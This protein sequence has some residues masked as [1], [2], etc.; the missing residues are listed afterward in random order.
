MSKRD[1]TGTLLFAILVGLLL[2]ALA[3]ASAD[4]IHLSDGRKLEGEI[5]KETEDSI[6]LKMQYGTLTI[7]RD[8]IQE[9]ERRV[10]PWQEY[11]RKAALLA[12][13]DAKGHFEL[14]LW[15]KEKGLRKEMTAELKKV[16][17]ALPDHE[18]AR[19]LLGYVKSAD[20]WVK[21]SRKPAP[22]KASSELKEKSAQEKPEPQAEQDKPP[23]DDFEKLVPKKYLEGVRAALQRAGSNAGELKKYLS[24]VP[25][26][27]REGA[28][29]LVAR[30]LTMDLQTL[31]AEMLLEH[32]E[33]AYKARKKFPWASKR[34]VPEEVFLAFVL[35]PRCYA[36]CTNE[37][38]KMKWRKH[39][40]E[41]LYP[42]LRRCRDL[43]QA[44]N[45]C[46]KY[47]ADFG[48]TYSQKHP[49]NPG[50]IGTTELKHAGCGEMSTLIQ[51]VCRSIGIPARR[52]FRPP[53]RGS[54]NHAWC[55]VYINGK[56]FFVESTS[57]NAQGII[58]PKIGNDCS[59]KVKSN[60]AM[61]VCEYHL[62]LTQEDKKHA[63][64]Y[65][66]LYPQI[67]YLDETHNS[68][69]ACQIRT[70]VL[71]ADATPAADVNLHYYV[72]GEDGTQKILWGVART[73]K[74]IAILGG[75]R[76]D[77]KGYANLFVNAHCAEITVATADGRARKLANVSR[78]ANK[79]MDVVLKLPPEE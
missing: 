63:V 6:I 4:V 45:I 72:E 2:L 74:G 41:S 25:D 38:N 20:K 46:F 26:K 56:W 40:Y 28:A 3:P 58:Q 34:V 52:L 43:L 24:S 57:R 67:H 11:A 5:V 21:P 65:C 16:I 35:C 19:K 36:K 77:E 37:G 8:E 68:G 69:K 15:C 49:R 76:T 1:A 64:G 12:N 59:A 18:E 55:E 7:E 70:R 9:I 73:A 51:A 54:D 14:A 48:I 61:L 53:G 33:Y 47:I 62:R 27:Q 30:L 50:P 75:Q 17:A 23:I 31:D 39:F 71:N 79:K 10:T 29:L 44:V 22:S 60:L 78:Y 32:T 66:C 13:S 42:L